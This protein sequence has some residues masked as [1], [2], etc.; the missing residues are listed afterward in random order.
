MTSSRRWRLIGV[1][2][3][4]GAYGV[5]LEHAPRVL[6]ECGLTG[7]IDADV[8][9]IG[10]LSSTPFR[11]DTH[12]R[13]SQNIETVVEVVES[14]REAVAAALLDGDVPLVVGGDC[15]ITLGV[16]AAVIS[17]MPDASLAYFDGDVDMSTPET[18]TSGVLDAMGVA[19][20]LNIDGADARLAAVGFETP[21]IDGEHLALIGF[22]VDELSEA[23]ETLLD[24][25]GVGRF[26]ASDLRRDLPGALRRIDRFLERSPRIVHFDVDAVD[27]IELPLAEFPHF[28]T[29]VGV[30]TASEILNHLCETSRLAALVI[31]EAN[32]RR[33]PDHLYM[34]QLA[35]LIADAANAAGQ[36]ATA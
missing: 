1:P 20:L 15:T 3:S 8:I 26:P 33:D 30:E 6:R 5:G 31:T 10:D 25:R 21:L 23:H 18:T 32:P 27:S 13:R 22:E 14:V 35:A 2:T 29:G 36:A 24:E 7:S 28:N 9:D 16:V 17:V 12:N 11:P 4:A 19:H 34:P